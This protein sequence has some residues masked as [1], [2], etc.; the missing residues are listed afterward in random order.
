MFRFIITSV[1][2]NILDSSS[3]SPVEFITSVASFVIEDILV[4]LHHMFVQHI[5]V[6]IFTFRFINFY[7]FSSCFICQ[8]PSFKKW[9]TSMPMPLF[10]CCLLKRKTVD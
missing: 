5:S 10:V 6:F 8:S 2:E 7:H 4:E 3:L 9:I 1:H